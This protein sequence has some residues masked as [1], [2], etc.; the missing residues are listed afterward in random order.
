MLVH[1]GTIDLARLFAHQRMRPLLVGADTP[2]AMTEAYATLKR[3]AQRPGWLAHDLLIVADPNGPRTERLGESLAEC[4]E[5]FLGAAIH[6][7]VVID[8]RHRAAKAP[9]RAWCTCCARR[10]RKTCCTTARRCRLAHH[11]PRR[12]LNHQQFTEPKTRGEP[13]MYTAKGQLTDSN[14]LLKQY[15]PLVRRLA[16]Q[17]IAKLPANVEL[18]DLIQ[19]GM[20]GLNDALSRFDADQG[21]HVR[22]LRHPTHPRRHARRA[23]RRRLDEPR[24]PA[25]PALDR[26]RRAQAR[27]EAAARAQR[28]RDRRRDGHDAG[29]LPGAARQGARHAAVLPGRPVGRRGRRLPRPPR[30]RRRRQPARHAAKTIACARRWSRP[31]A[32]C[33]SASST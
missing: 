9:T 21:V 32:S 11:A 7:C 13:F 25:P 30:G 3:L 27:A 28:K 29:R 26:S 33:P 8:P 10:W 6:D 5:R 14:A 24:R 31:S 17:M 15:S 22:D 23:A 2:R 1:A 19:V 4:A 12:A 16:H 20:I 18:D